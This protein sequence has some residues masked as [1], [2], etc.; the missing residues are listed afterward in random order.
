MPKAPDVS[1]MFYYFPSLIKSEEGGSHARKLA[2][3]ES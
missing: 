2:Q 3:V 1:G